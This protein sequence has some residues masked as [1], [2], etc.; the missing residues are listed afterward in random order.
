MSAKHTKESAMYAKFI[1]V[2]ISGFPAIF[3]SESIKTGSFTSIEM[4]TLTGDC[5][6]YASFEDRRTINS[7]IYR[8]RQTCRSTVED[9]SD[10]RAFFRRSSKFC[11]IGIEDE[12]M[13]Y[14]PIAFVDVCEFFQPNPKLLDTLTVL[15]A[16]LL[17]NADFKC[18][19]VRYN[20]DFRT[21]AFV[22]VYFI[23]NI[24]TVAER[25]KNEQIEQWLKLGSVV[26]E[27][28][29]R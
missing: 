6:A 24:A 15:D 11:L 9:L 5:C 7:S 16:E 26:I 22:K 4:E 23:Y 29:P 17:G 21:Q 13:T 2:L 3:P 19:S 20:K 12:V 27:L 14:R 28:F 25:T 18:R 8:A 1:N 10:G